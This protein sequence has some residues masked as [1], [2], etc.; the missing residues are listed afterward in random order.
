MKDFVQLC[1]STIDLLNTPYIK[2]I[3]YF[4]KP[5]KANENVLLEITIHR[6]NASSSLRIPV[7]P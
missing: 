5:H 7:F 3:T 4:R 2:Q 6:R 1:I